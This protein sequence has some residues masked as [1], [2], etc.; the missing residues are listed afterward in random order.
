M[1]YIFSVSDECEDKAILGNKGANLITMTK[2]G[3]PV[4]LGFIISIDAFRA[5]QETGHLPEEEIEQAVA[6][7]ERQ[8]GQ[9][10]GKN[11][12]VSVR[13]STPVSMPGMMDTLLNIGDM[14]QI[15]ITVEQVFGSWNSPRAVEYRRVSGIPFDLGTSAIVQAMVFGNKN[16]NSGTGVVFTRNPTTTGTCKIL[17]LPLN[18]AS[19]ISCKLGLGR[20]VDRQR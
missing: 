3:L 18:L 12:K 20:E 16:A 7:L 14:N 11:L 19:S 15:K 8:T 13:S 5:Y 1:Q 4:P 2:L 6:T 10:L 9:R 17:S